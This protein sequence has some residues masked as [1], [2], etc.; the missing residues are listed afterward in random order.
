MFAQARAGQQQ[1]T[2]LT[3]AL[4]LRPRTASRIRLM[5]RL[6]PS[7]GPAAA[8]LQNWAAVHHLMDVMGVSERFA[9]RVTGQHRGTQ[10]YCPRSQSPADPDAALRAWRRSYARAHPRWG[11]GGPITMPPA[12]DG[13]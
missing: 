8:A 5:R 1:R 13:R 10:R 11:T 9:C 2:L 6:S 3:A 4:P 12:R 7:C